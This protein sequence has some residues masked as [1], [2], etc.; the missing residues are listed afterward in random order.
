MGVIGGIKGQG[1]VRYIY[2]YAASEL[3]MSLRSYA[4]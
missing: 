4:T 3:E 2:I 1:I